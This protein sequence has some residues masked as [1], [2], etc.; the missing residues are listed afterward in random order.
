MLEEEV[1]MTRCVTRDLG[2]GLGPEKKTNASINERQ[3][4]LIPCGRRPGDDTFENRRR[5]GK[6]ERLTW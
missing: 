2:R 5:H 4:G 1:N 6:N 3:Y